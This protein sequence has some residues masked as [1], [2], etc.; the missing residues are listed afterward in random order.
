[1]SCIMLICNKKTRQHLLENWKASSINFSLYAFFG[2]Y[3]NNSSGPLPSHGVLISSEEKFSPS[4][5][6]PL[7]ELP[8][9]PR[10]LR[11]KKKT[12]KISRKRAK[13]C[14]RIAW[15]FTFFQ[16]T[17]HDSLKIHIWKSSYKW[18]EMILR[19]PICVCKRKGQRMY[20]ILGSNS[21]PLSIVEC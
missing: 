8:T 13:G 19:T 1:M 17:A 18:A 7:V 2:P 4:I 15:M 5:Q 11:E 14:R 21:W 3:K 6:Q 9:S 12:L 10:R 20:L 16:R